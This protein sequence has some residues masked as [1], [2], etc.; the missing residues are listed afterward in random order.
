MGTRHAPR[1]QLRPGPVVIVSPELLQNCTSS[2]PTA[3]AVGAKPGPPRSAKRRA[4]ESIGL[5]S[6]WSPR[7][8]A[9]YLAAWNLLDEIGEDLKVYIPLATRPNGTLNVSKLER[10][11]HKALFR[12]LE[13]SS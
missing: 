8:G 4:A 5:L 11:A 2:P 1:P 10:L 7:T 12:D 13:R 9:K 3:R 6:D